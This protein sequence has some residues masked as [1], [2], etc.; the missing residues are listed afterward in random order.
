LPVKISWYAFS[1]R[2]FADHRRFDVVVIGGG[3]AGTEAS[4]AAAR[5]GADTLL[6]THKRETIGEMSCNPSFGGI[7]KGHLIREVDALD[8]KRPVL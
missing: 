3:H 2:T 6:V 5:M 1:R 7:G 8:G 4:A